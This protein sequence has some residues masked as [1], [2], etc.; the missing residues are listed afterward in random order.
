VRCSRVF[1]PKRYVELEVD[2][3]VEVTSHAEVALGGHYVD[4]PLLTGRNAVGHR[5]WSSLVASSAARLVLNSTSRPLQGSR[6][7]R[8][9]GLGRRVTS[10]LVRRWTGLRGFWLVSPVRPLSPQYSRWT[11]RNSNLAANKVCLSN[12]TPIRASAKGQHTCQHFS[13]SAVDKICNHCSLTRS[14]NAH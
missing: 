7:P 3:E 5:R 8:R 13:C 12:S 6:S 4:P 2:G 9:P 1:G 14:G 10:I 11:L